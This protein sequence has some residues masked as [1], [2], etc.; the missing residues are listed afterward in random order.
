MRSGA[1]Q[2]RTTIPWQEALDSQDQG[3]WDW[4]LAGGRIWFSPRYLASLGYAA[5]SSQTQWREQLHADDRNKADSALQRHLRGELA[6]FASAHRVRAADGGYRWVAMRGRVFA[7]AADGSPARMLG[8]QHDIHHHMLAQLALRNS[9]ARFRQLFEDAPIGMS[10]TSTQW[11]WLD[12][13]H[14]FCQLLGYDKDEL[15]RLQPGALTHPDDIAGDHRVIA[16]L[17]GGSHRSA[18]RFKRYRHRNGE[19]IDAQLD[20]TLIRDEHGHPQYFVTLVQDMRERR[21]HE[22]ALKAEKALAQVTLAAISDGVLRSDHLGRISFCNEAAAAMLGYAGEADSLLGQPFATVVRLHREHGSAALVDPSLAPAGESL[23]FLPPLL[24][25][26]ARRGELRPIEITRNSLRDHGNEL[27]CVFVLHDLSRIRRLSEQLI[28]QASHDLLTDLPNRREFQAELAHRLSTARLA[29]EQHALLYLD[30][31]QFKL[32][33]EIAGHVAGDRMIYEIALQLRRALPATA[34]LARMGGDEFAI[35]LPYADAAAARELADN[36]T[37][38]IGDYRFEHDA[39]V[40]TVGVSIGI[41]MID[42][43]VRDAHAV[44]A[45]ADS[46]CYIAKRQGGGRLQLYHASDEVVRQAHRDS[47]WASR[48]QQALDTGQ[49]QLHAQQIHALAGRLTPNYEVLIRIVDEQGQLQLPGAFLSAAER[50]GL[51]GRV[52][53]WV[54]QQTLQ[55]VA[56][57]A[58]RHALLPFGYLSINLTGHSVS[59]AAFADFVLDTLASYRIPPQLLRFEITES[60]ALLGFGTAQKFVARLR[61]LGCRVMLDDFG[62]GFT[63]FEYLRRMT[64]DGLKI[65]QGYTQNLGSDR[66]NQTIVEAICRI[67]R[68]LQLEIVAEGV[69]DTASLDL[70]RQLG[71]DF[72]QGHLFHTS[73]PLSELLPS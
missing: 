59:D 50:Y 44:L 62:S 69:E 37:Q 61:E 71:V 18:R 48:I 67:G 66:L 51:S 39:R 7:R 25:L 8:T 43:G 65:D 70:L 5:I 4:D 38:L 32:I 45:Q 2:D 55:R 16:Q 19:L 35:L 30:L 46:A 56:D 14:A 12:V 27:G 49:L 11:Q 20:T 73:V 26:R 29:D 33:N 60:A 68:A 63:S 22:E 23:P 40:Y 31:D 36:L 1:A 6:E 41:S 3:L 58:S 15:L 47:D 72:V 64:V 24:Y 52:D 53:R 42:A 17:V 13:N 57:Y 34:M 21:R 54:V 28:H 10:L 9:E